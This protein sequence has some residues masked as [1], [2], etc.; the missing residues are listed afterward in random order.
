MKSGTT[1]TLTLMRFTSNCV[2][3]K[4]KKSRKFKHTEKISDPNLTNSS[5]IQLFK[6][7][8][9]N[10]YHYAPFELDHSVRCSNS[11]K[12][13]MFYKIAQTMKNICDCQDNK[14]RYAHVKGV[15][16]I[17]KKMLQFTISVISS[18]QRIFEWNYSVKMISK[19]VSNILEIN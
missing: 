1:T 18:F 7:S 11:Y 9:R 15:W 8:I 13:R 3:K 19:R 16:I 5:L 10:Q 6:S 14:K 4:P 12:F 17:K 2:N